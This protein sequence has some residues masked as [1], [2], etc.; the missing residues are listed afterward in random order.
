MPAILT[1]TLMATE[2]IAE[3]LRYIDDYAAAAAAECVRR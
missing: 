1:V 3:D 2:R